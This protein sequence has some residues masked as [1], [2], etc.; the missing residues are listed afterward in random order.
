M[1]KNSTSKAAESCFSNVILPEDIVVEILS[2]LSLASLQRFTCVSKLWRSLI[3]DVSAAKARSPAVLLVSGSRACSFSPR[4]IDRHDHACV[5]RVSVPWNMDEFISRFR[6]LGSCDGLLLMRI[7]VDL[8]LWNPLTAFFKRVLAYEPLRYDYRV[9]SGLCYDSA[10]D[11]Y[12]AVLALARH[13]P[14]WDDVVVGSFRSKSW[15]RIGFP[16]KVHTVGSGPVVNGNIHWFA[17]RK[18]SGILSPHQIIYFNACMDKF[19]EVPMPEPKGEDGDIICGLGVLDGYLCM[20]RSDRRP[21]DNESNVEVL[22]MKEYGVKNCWTTLFVVSD[23]FTFSHCDLLAPLGYTKNGRVLTKV[24]VCED[25]DWH[26]KA[27]DLTKNSYRRISIPKEKDHYID[28]I[29]YEESLITPNDDDWEEEEFEEA[30]TYV[31]YSPHSR[32]VMRRARAGYWWT[33]VYT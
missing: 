21:G 12:K 13:S 5:E 6:I 31:E 9:R 16:Y 23:G 27:F 1:G 28:V 4:S 20:S 14:G 8:F 26:I 18:D 32:K 33:T 7:D 11:E 24:Y 15:K 25:R 3:S 17:S 22:I 30:S 29:V 2:R 19:E 10:S